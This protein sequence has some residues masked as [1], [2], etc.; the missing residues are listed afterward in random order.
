MTAIQEHQRRVESLTGRVLVLDRSVLAFA[1]KVAVFKRTIEEGLHAKKMSLCPFAYQRM[2]VALG[3]ADIDA[4]ENHAGRVGE[5]VEILD[6]AEQ[7]RGGSGLGSQRAIGI[8]HLAEDRIPAL[9]FCQ[10]G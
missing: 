10:R 3:T 5:V 1:E 6:L 2:V 9:F 4:K 7:E 8:D